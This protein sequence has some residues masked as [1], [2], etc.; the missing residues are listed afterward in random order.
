MSDTI[1]RIRENQEAKE[2]GIIRCIPL[3]NPRLKSVFPGVIRGEPV[4][5][6]GNTS[7]GK[8]TLTKA[9]FVYGPIEYA[10]KNNL[11]LKILY[12]GLEESKR[13]F[14]YGLLSYLLFKEHKIRLNIRE[15]DAMGG[16]L[17]PRELSLIEEI[18]PLFE[19]WKSYILWYDSFFTPKSILSTVMR[20]AY[21]EGKFFKDGTLVLDDELRV[22]ED[23]SWDTYVPD[24][25]KKFRIVIV[26]HLR[27][28]RPPS[29]KTTKHEAMQEWSDYNQQIISYKFDYAGIIVQQQSA[30]ADNF[31]HVK[32][33][34]WMPKLETLGG[35]REVGQDARTII[36]IGNPARYRVKKFEGYDIE[37]FEGFI[38]FA[39]VLKQ[40]YGPT[41]K[42]IPLFFD[43]KT[44]MIDVMPRP[45]D[46]TSLDI[47]LKYIQGL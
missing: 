32:H 30:E 11:D 24:D 40:T 16:E 37:E 25:P 38:R 22:G 29:S 7:S 26:D 8:T 18:Q 2:R 41:N 44:G 19:K 10:I 36:G 23:G 3:P 4:T 45:D 27:K 47:V 13:Q 15:F 35:N 39:E 9:W 12:F 20:F 28:L 33:G 21:N 14:E 34:A 6:S 43:G 31:D 42:L 46:K 17:T 5:L 1:K